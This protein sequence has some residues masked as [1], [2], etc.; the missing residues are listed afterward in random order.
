MAAAKSLNR[1]MVGLKL[2]LEIEKIGGH[3]KFESNHG[4]I[5]T[6]IIAP[7]R[8]V[9]G[10]FE[11]NHGGIETKTCAGCIQRNPGFESNHGGIETRN[12]SKW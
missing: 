8:F 7:L 2:R 3:Q 9:K 6:I 10:G 5:E 4:G 12:P 1:I 11:S